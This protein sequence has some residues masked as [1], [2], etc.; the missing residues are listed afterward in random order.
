MHA[1]ILASNT[2]ACFHILRP[3]VALFTS[4]V[5]ETHHIPVYDV[6]PP[7]RMNRSLWLAFRRLWKSSDSPWMR[8]WPQALVARLR[9]VSGFQIL[10]V[11]DL[12]RSRRTIFERL[13]FGIYFLH[14]AAKSDFHGWTS[15]KHPAGKKITKQTK[16]DF[17]FWSSKPHLKCWWVPNYSSLYE[18]VASKNDSP[19]TNLKC[20]VSFSLLCSQC[21]ASIFPL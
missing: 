6:G 9:M 15:R 16:F 2:P 17:S 20:S 1:S 4:P 8:P 10:T 5:I 12:K 3:E 21:T 19:M 7:P 18:I 11:L 14:L 13:I